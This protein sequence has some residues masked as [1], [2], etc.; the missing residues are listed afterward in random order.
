[1]RISDWSSDVCSSDLIRMKISSPAN[2]LPNS[3]SASDTGL[4][5]SSTM[6]STTLTGNSQGPNGCVSTSLP[7]PSMPLTLKLKMYI[8]TTPDSDM[9]KVMLMSVLGTNLRYAKS[10]EGRVG[11]EWVGKWRNGWTP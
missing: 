10:E 7:K 5:M 4:A 2:R 6:R 1:M 8:N 3:R 11:K 9:P